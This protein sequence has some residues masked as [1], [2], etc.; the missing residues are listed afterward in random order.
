MKLAAEAAFLELFSVVDREA[1]VFEEFINKGEGE[2]MEKAL[3]RSMTDYFKRVAVRLGA[4]ARERRE[5]DGGGGM[6]LE[7]E[8]EDEREV[9][10]V[11]KVDLGEEGGRGIE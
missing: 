5:A 1:E 3:K 6:E 9:W 10:S 7:G 11:G 4:V 2:E 8:E